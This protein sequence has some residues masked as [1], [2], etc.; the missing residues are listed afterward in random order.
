MNLL[1]RQTDEAP[2]DKER[3]VVEKQFYKQFYLKDGKINIEL[4]FKHLE[5]CIESHEEKFKKIEFQTQIKGPFWMKA[6]IFFISAV[7]E[8]GAQSVCQYFFYEKYFMALD[9]S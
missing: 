8:N 4:L 2:S 9:Q 1:N 3:T 5:A 7:L 6:V